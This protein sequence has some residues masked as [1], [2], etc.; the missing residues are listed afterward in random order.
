MQVS[1]S[2][3]NLVNGV[4]QQAENLRFSSQC[5]EEINAAASVV[6][7]LTKRPHTSHIATLPLP[8][9][10]FKSYAIN[11]SPTEQYQLMLGSQYVKVFDLAGTEYPVKKPDGSDVTP[12]D[13]AYLSTTAPKTSLK[14][15]TVA[16]YT[17]LLNT[18]RTVALSPVVS[19]SYWTAALVFVKNIRQGSDYKIRLYDD[20]L[21]ASTNAVD[22]EISVLSIETDLT[23][24]HPVGPVCAD[25][26]DVISALK[27]AMDGNAA[28]TVYD[29]FFQ[30]PLLFITKKDGS[31]FRI[32]VDSTLVEGMAVFKDSVESFSLLPKLGWKDFVLKVRGDPDTSGDDYY[33]K[34]VAQDANVP[35]GFCEGSWVESQAPALQDNLDPLT[36]PHGLLNHGSYFTYQPL[37]WGARTCGDAK[38]NP[39]PSFVGKTIRDVFFY[40]DRLALLADQNSLMSEEAEFFNFFRTTVIQLLDSDPI[41]VAASNSKVSILNSAVATSDHLVFFSD[42]TQFLLNSGDLL[43]PK[44]VAI[45][46]TTELENIG[47]LRPLAI[48]SSV[49]FAVKR[50]PYSGFTEYAVA[51]DTQLFEGTDI[52]EHVPRYL[53]GAVEQ[54]DVSSL[55]NI[56][57]A[58]LS[59]S[60]NT[61][62]AYRFFKQNGA[63]LQSAWGKWTFSGEVKSFFIL[64]TKLY[65]NINRDDVLSFEAIELTPGV[66]DTDATY[67]A[68]LDR[69][70]SESSVSSSYDQNTNVTTFTLPYVPSTGLARIFKRIAPPWPGGGAVAVRSQT[71]NV[72]RANGNFTGVPLWFGENYRMEYTMTRPNLRVMKGTGEFVIV[73]GRFQVG[74]GILAHSNSLYFRVEVSP[75][76][77]PTYS[78][79]YVP[80]SLGT[81]T[82][83]TGTP[84]NPVDGIKRFPVFSKNDQV[85][86][87]II[88]DSP[89]PCSLISVDWEAN[90]TARAQRV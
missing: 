74:Y 6:T 88:N 18:D 48:G 14:P 42:Q 65:V 7:G 66:V 46:P 1:T 20:A 70:V 43:T 84:L 77:R 34:F 72:L 16:D 38:S 19:P 12:A 79:E 60:S 27:V 81:S 23:A 47:T 53:S 8:V 30:G 21:A 67:S 9:G 90:Y 10:D 26:G 5:T 80:R 32:E 78:Y 69:R 35:S 54:F 83:V 64:G 51:S 33:V 49:F 73:P 58:K 45:T 85:T 71:G 25:Q 82:A 13:L 31:D 61:L 39:A 52:S 89:L 36:L 28:S 63:R 41:D 17:L 4:S 11:R 37:E 62:Y 50:G 22:H 55:T 87:K 2:V 59:G 56:L 40:K 29:Y 24:A 3:P 76:G 86:I 75:I 68:H 15:L 44:T 57:I